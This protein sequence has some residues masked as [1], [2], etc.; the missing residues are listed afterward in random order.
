M[1]RV[2]VIDDEENILKTLSGILSGEGYESVTA[3]TGGDGLL[4][5]SSKLIDCV[6]LD[7]WLP[8]IDGLQVLRE[9]RRDY[10]MTPVIMMSGHSTISTA[11]DAT[12]LGAFTFLEKPLDLD[13]LL[14]AIRNALKLA[15]LEKENLILREDSAKE[16]V[17]VGDSPVL[18]RLRSLI[19]QVAST[20]SRI[21]IT[22][23]NG[24]GKE[25][26]ARMIYLSSNR[27]GKPF[28]K[29]NCAA[30]PSELIESE[31]FGHEKGAFTGATEA[32]Q[33][34]FEL[35]DG[36]TLFLDEIGDMSH[37]AQ[38]KVLRVIEEQEFERVGG[39]KP[40]RVDVRV[41]VATNQDLQEKIKSGEFRED[42]YFRLNVIPVH[43][44]P[45][46]DHIEDIPAIAS[47]FLAHYA[48]ENNR[49][50][51]RLTREAVEILKNYS[52][53]GNVRELRNTMERLTILAP[54]D[55][56]TKTDLAGII[57][58]LDRFVPTARPVSVETEEA[59]FTKFDSA[60]LKE[61]VAECERSIILRRLAACD[62]NVKKTA[63]TLGLER[64]HLYKKMRTLGIDPSKKQNNRTD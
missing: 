35:A 28:V 4:L 13:R 20:S 43:V 59:F 45:L 7:V 48:I 15:K 52:W 8:D 14:L 3:P 10:P 11:V 60:G 17:L 16:P 40:I 42:L 46:R 56:I 21:L 9:L 30:I 61:S 23:E 44:P 5:A 22:G 29:V 6:L 55:E 27:K 57:P 51:K 49:R 41:I 38:A 63:E 2:L 37:G 12:K 31:L 33:G 1:V 34:K 18:H 25:I 39:K 50:T 62:G 36:G 58:G 64:S 19:A 32:K 24:T 47:H 53:P 26:V 54:G